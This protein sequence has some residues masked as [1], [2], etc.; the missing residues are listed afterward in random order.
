MSRP[1][2][3][4]R[5]MIVSV[6]V[7]FTCGMWVWL[8]LLLTAGV[9]YPGGQAWLLSQWG[10]PMVAGITGAVFGPVVAGGADG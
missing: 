1:A 8:L 6:A 7:G 3:T 10:P 5:V 4:L 9:V 2:E